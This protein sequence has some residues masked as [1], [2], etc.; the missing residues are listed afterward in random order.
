MNIL[1]FV[2][3]FIK[4]RINVW[5]GFHHTSNPLNLK[6]RWHHW[7]YKYSLKRGRDVS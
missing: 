5:L 1:L 3:Y 4:L 6:W 2:I 7:N